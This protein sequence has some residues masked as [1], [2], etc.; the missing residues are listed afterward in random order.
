MNIEKQD[1]EEVKEDRGITVHSLRRVLQT[2]NPLKRAELVS[3]IVETEEIKELALIP[4]EPNY[5]LPD[6]FLSAK[7]L[8]EC[9]TYFMQ[10][11]KKITQ[12]EIEDWN[13]LI[14]EAYDQ[15]TLYT[16]P[17]EKEPEI[18]KSEDP[19]QLKATIERILGW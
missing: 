6:V 14:E 17:I 19:E 9:E 8:P 4:T 13:L 12:K 5:Q 2:Q 18:K 10:E 15:I 16:K 3:R 7:I 11:S 1:K